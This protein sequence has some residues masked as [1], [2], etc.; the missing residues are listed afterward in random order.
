MNKKLNT[1]LLKSIIDSEFLILSN[2]SQEGAGKF[3]QKVSS[4]GD[5]NARL[6][7]NLFEVLKSLKQLVRVLQFLKQKNKKELVICCPDINILSFLDLYK[8]ELKCSNLLKLEPDCKRSF[9]KSKDLKSLLLLEEPLGN[10]SSALKKLFEE[11]I[12]IIYK[13]NSVLEVNSY[14]TYK[15]YNDVSNFKKLAFLVTLVESILE[16]DL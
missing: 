16:T 4:K 5:S 1:I 11:N 7:L 13:I 3:D 14:G 10:K 6:S 15:M 2:R 9:G 12:L 8:K